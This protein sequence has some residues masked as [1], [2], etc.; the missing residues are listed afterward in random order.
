[1]DSI[2]LNG[3]DNTSTTSFS[4][5][6]DITNKIKEIEN[7]I[8]ERLS[9]N[10]VSVRKAFLDMDEDYDGYLTAEDFSKL[11]GGSSGNSKY[12]YNFVKMLLK[13]RTK[14]ANGN[15]NYTDFC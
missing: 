14:H 7:V 15:I 1:V 5:N 9:N 3:I 13:I 11:I 2:D 8:K 4:K 6:R 12:D 10:W